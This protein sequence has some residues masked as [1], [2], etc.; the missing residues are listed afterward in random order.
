M[1][2]SNGTVDVVGNLKMKP[3]KHLLAGVVRPKGIGLDPPS[4]RYLRAT[5]MGRT[6]SAPVLPALQGYLMV[7]VTSLC[8]QMAITGSV[9]GL[10][11]PIL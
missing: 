8:F 5:F 7:A 3:Q 9:C 1:L 6:T 11:A 2:H 10:V 4:I